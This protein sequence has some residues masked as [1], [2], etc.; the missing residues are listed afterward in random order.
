MLTTDGGR[1]YTVTKKIRLGTSGN[2]DGYGDLGTRVPPRTGTAAAPP[3]GEFKAI[4]GCNDCFA[5]PGGSLSQPAFLQTW[6]DNGTSLLQTQNQSI[7]Y[8][9]TPAA[10]TAPGFGFS[11]PDQ[12]IV[13]TPSGDLLMA[14][15]GHAKDGYKN[16][17]K[18]T[19]VFYTSSDDGLMWSYLSRVDVTPAMVASKGGAGE[20]P[21]EPSMATLADGRVLA[22]FRLDASVPL[23]LAY[24]PDNGKTW[25]DPA[26][27]IGAQAVGTPG[28]ADV[29]FAV[30]PQLLVLSNGALV[31]ASGRPG[32][33]F[34]VSPEAD[35]ARWVGYD[36][37]AEHSRNLPS[38][39]WDAAHGDGSTEYTGIAEVES[40][41][42]L[43]AY[44]KTSGAGRSGNVQKVYSVRI[45]VGAPPMAIVSDKHLTIHTTTSPSPSSPPP[46]TAGC[47]SDLDCAGKNGDCQ[48][49]TGACVCHAGWSGTTCSVMA[50]TPK[51]GRVAYPTTLWTWGGSPILDEATG[52]FHLFS[53]E[54][55]NQ[56]GIL[57]YCSNSR[58]IHL[59]SP[60]ATGPYERR[61]IVLAPRA[62]PAW[63]NGAVHGVSV[64]RLP[65][66]TYA[67]LYMGTEEPGMNDTNRP[68]CT[69][70]SGDTTANR[71]AGSHSGRR[72]GIATSETLAVGATWRRLDAP[73]FG[74]GRKGE[75][76][77]DT[78]VS[79][80][81]PI[82]A[83][84]GS[85]VMLYKGN[86][87]TKTGQHM[88]LAF[89]PSIDG[90]YTRNDSGKGARSR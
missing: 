75:A 9:N 82:I 28:T 56:C 35:G 19:T 33:G 76:W 27:A 7:T 10:L 66:G 59:T 4:V 51:S 62:P 48:P 47:A 14:L 21:C 65:N 84:D 22:A 70:G 31:L 63:D 2:F 5:H 43:L 88:G 13:R 11:A 6:L 68:N 3:P 69:A 83:K 45:K 55:S 38:D 57:H 26:P 15:Y 90:P 16:G 89:A 18:Y 73:L 80:P 39:P 61:E 60:N 41:V 46:T 25:T 81:S 77:D 52:I 42:V 74:P 34:W 40:G 78:D 24:S 49:T 8:T 17:T 85:V 37:E 50:F 30:W 58:V 44:D 87:D 23:W 71:T 86:G 36:V 53:S 54:I 29:V 67:L 72:V 1:S 79:N 64:H 32:I 20:G 12:S